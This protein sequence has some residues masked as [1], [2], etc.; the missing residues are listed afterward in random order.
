M[1]E[2]NI[3]KETG[4]FDFVSLGKALNKIFFFLS[5][6]TGWGGV[7]RPKRWPSPTKSLQVKRDLTRMKEPESEFHLHTSP[8]NALEIICLMVS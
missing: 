5:R 7:I 6:R 1:H 4:K 2:I 8:E 3:G